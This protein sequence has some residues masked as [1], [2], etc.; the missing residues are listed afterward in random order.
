MAERWRAPGGWT[1]QV[2]VLAGTPDRH[3]GEWLR[4]TQYGSWVADV[5]TV[6]ELAQWFPL[7]DLEPDG[8]TL[9]A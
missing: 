3:D 6:A 4:V 1:V 2:V 5:R 8:L 9:A 7:A